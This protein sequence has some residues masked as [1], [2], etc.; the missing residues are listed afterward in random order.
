MPKSKH[1]FR[2]NFR[3]CVDIRTVV[4]YNTKSKQLFGHEKGVYLYE[5]D[6]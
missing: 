3:F 1:L 2:T 5:T 6:Y 4:C